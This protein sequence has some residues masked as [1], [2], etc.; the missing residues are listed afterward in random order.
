MSRLA[1]FSMCIAIAVG[2]LASGATATASSER[3]AKA[4]L[5]PIADSGIRAEIEFHDT[6]SALIVEG[7]AR[8]LDPTKTYIS[9]IYDVGS[10]PTGPTACEPTRGPTQSGFLN[11]PKMFV[12]TWSQNGQGEGHLKVTKTGPSYTAIGTFRT[13]SVRVVVA[14]GLPQLRACGVVVAKDED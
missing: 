14:V 8:G 13:V 1:A 6:G 4:R 7:E 11:F 9:L 5:A 3:E 2:A 12:G 10:V